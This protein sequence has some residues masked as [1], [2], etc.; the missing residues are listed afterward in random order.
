MGILLLFPLRGVEIS[1]SPVP[2]AVEA[3][4]TVAARGVEVLLPSS[5]PGATLCLPAGLRTADGCWIADGV[6]CV[7]I[8][9]AGS[10][11]ACE[12]GFRCR[13]AAEATVLVALGYSLS[14]LRAASSISRPVGTCHQ[15]N[16]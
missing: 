16:N 2:C 12:V 6:C 9:L 15:L 3:R 13:P 11:F 4:L 10:V 7:R 8:L 1:L 5:L 14:V